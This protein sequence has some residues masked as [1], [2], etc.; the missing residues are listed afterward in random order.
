MATVKVFNDMFDEKSEEFVYDTSRPLLEQIEEHLDKDFYKSTMVECYDPQTGETFYAP[1]EDDDETE[2][3]IILVNGQSVDKDFVPEEHDVVNVIFTPLGGPNATRGAALGAWLGATAAI[4]ATAAISLIPGVNV[5]WYVVVGA[6]L[7]GGVWGGYI[8]WDKGKEKDRAG[9][10]LNQKDGKDSDQLPDV[11]GC[12]NQSLV[13]NNFP[14]VIGKHLVTPFIV[15]DPYT[16]YV[17]GRGKDAYVRILLCV[18]YGPLKLTDFKLGDYMLAYNRTHPVN[19]KSYTTMPE[20]AVEGM[21]VKYAGTTGTYVNGKYYKYHSGS[22]GVTTEYRDTATGSEVVR[23]T[24]MAGLLTGYST[25]GVPDNGD[26]VDFWSNNSVSIEII[27]QSN[28]DDELGYG[29]AAYADQV[30]NGD[31]Y[32]FGTLYPEVT[33]EQKVDANCFYIA[34]KELQD[35]VPVSYKGVSFPNKYRTN[36]VILTDSCPREFTINLDLPSGLYRTRTETS[37]NTS[38]VVYSPI[39]LWMCIQWR[40]YSTENASSKADGSDYNDWNTVYFNSNINRTFDNTSPGPGLAGNQTFDKNLHQ[41]NDFGSATLEDIYQGFRDKELQSFYNYAGENGIDE[42]RFSATVTLTKEQCKQVIADTNPSRCIEVRCLRVSPNYM[43]QLED[44]T[45]DGK[46]MWSYSDHIKVSTVVTK[47]FDYEELR[48]NDELIPTRV[49]SEKDLRKLC[50]VAISCK[51]DA[52]GFIQ[53]NLDQITCTAESFSPIWDSTEK[54]ILPEGITK[55]EKYYGYFVGNTNTRTNRSTTATEREVTKADYEQARHDGYNWYAEKCGSNFTELMKD[56]A[57]VKSNV[58]YHVRSVWWLPDAAKK[59]NDNLSS[60]SFLLSLFG[61]QNGPE[62]SGMEDLNV[63]SIADWAETIY[64]LEDGSTA[65][66]AMDYNGVHYNTGDILPVRYEANAYIYAGIK[67]EDLLQK[68]AFT[69]RAVWVVDESGKVK[70]VFDGPVPYTKGAIASENCI[71]SS[72]AYT[73]EE[74]PAGLF[75]TFHDENDGYENNSFYV[76]SDGNSMKN[77]HGAVE[78]F[79]ADFVTNNVQMHSLARYSL[80]NR[81]LNREVLTRKIGPGG[82]IYSLGDVV[83][84][85]GEDLLIGDVSGRVQEVIE[86]D[87]KIYGFITDAVYTYT[88]ETVSQYRSTQGVTVI[89]QRYAGRSN[90][91]TFRL[92]APVTKEINGKTYVLQP[93]ETNLVLFAP[94]VVLGTE[95]WG[96]DKGNDDPSPSR[97]NQV[98]Y[99]IKTGD[100]AMYG[101]A[102]KIS[103]PYRIIKIKPEANGCFTE[104]L[105]P[106]NEDLYNY[107]AALPTFQSYITPP[108]AMVD[109]TSVS[110]VPTTL[111]D[112]ND[113]N[114]SIYKVFFARVAELYANHIVTLYKYS[115]TD[116]STAGIGT[117]LVYNFSD[118]SITWGDPSLNNGW[119][120]TVP[121]DLTDVW[122]TSATAYGQSQTDTINSNEWARPIKVGQNGVNGLNTCTISLYKRLSSTPQD[123]PAAVT[124]NFANASMVCSNWNGWSTSIP[125]VDDEDFTPCWEIHATALSTQTTDTIESSEWS[126]CVKILSEGLSKQDVLDLIGERINET[127]NVLFT[128]S[129]GMFA[130]DED[131]IVSTPQTAFMDVRVIQNDEDITFSFGQIDLP[132][133]MTV[134]ATVLEQGTR[135][136]FTVAQG[137]RL[138]RNVIKVPVIFTAYADNDVLVDENGNPLVWV[139]DEDGRWYGDC[140]TVASLPVAVS[141]GFIYWKGIDTTASEELVEGGVFYEGTFY[142]YNGTKWKESKVKPIG[143]QTEATSPTTYDIYYTASIVKGGRYDG[144][145]T[146]VAS[147][148]SNPVIGDYFTWTGTDQTPY[149]GSGFT[150]LAS[151]CVYKWNGSQ[152]EKDTSGKHLGTALPDILE[153]AESELV[154][155]NSDVVEKVGKM[156]AWNVVTQNIKVTGEALINSAIIA[157]LTLGDSTHQTSGE[158]KSYN[159]SSGSAGFKIKADGTAEFN[160]VTVRGTVY[161]SSGSFSGAI[162]AT[163]LT[164]GNGVT[165]PSNKVSGLA[166]VATSGDFDDLSNVEVELNQ[167]GT[168]VIEGG[169]I[170]TGLIDTDNL[171]AQRIFVKTG[172]SIESQSYTQGSA[173]WKIKDDGT[174][175]FNNVTIRGSVVNNSFSIDETDSELMVFKHYDYDMPYGSFVY[176]FKEAFG[177]QY[178]SAGES[179]SFDITLTDS[180]F[181]LYRNQGVVADNCN[182][183]TLDFV[184]SDPSRSATSD[185]A[186]CKLRV[187]SITRS[188]WLDI[189]DIGSPSSGYFQWE[190]VTASNMTQLSVFN[191]TTGVAKIKYGVLP[192]TESLENGVLFNDNGL[193]KISGAYQPWKY[194]E[195]N[196]GTDTKYVYDMIKPCITTQYQVSCMGY[197]GKSDSSHSRNINSISAVGGNLKFYNHNDTEYLSIPSS[198]NFG[199]E[200]LGGK[201]AVMFLSV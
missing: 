67:I 178:N 182:R 149:E 165:V 185:P 85:Q 141:G 1:M 167:L 31:T 132:T 5:A 81:I 183:F 155:N 115:E 2:G 18:G 126:E 84:I 17:G 21:V 150:K 73:Y 43:N 44:N 175:E 11:R 156:I 131:G 108:P 34:D 189:I 15:G 80:A 124:Y 46:G 142:T 187:Y 198:R 22:W 74:P 96:Y 116:L 152:W 109:P 8:G 120:A 104:T 23:N 101:L 201:L 110:D 61:A 159:Y 192:L 58:P 154:E 172:G 191:E 153:V 87:E 181:Y 114:K 196:E 94:R 169:K 188:M 157:D 180:Y 158:I 127:P 3:V 100:I 49:V 41:G 160:N 69:G 93:G 78:Q 184:F 139:E 47:T 118:D 52:S 125:E 164:L 83:L 32:G 30:V 10:K 57:M 197:Y 134:S 92:S 113:S 59:Y 82:A 199:Q 102:D 90:A 79:S 39:T 170:K 97:S 98:K 147:I 117:T 129:E 20:S 76:W 16:F 146:T 162:T 38:Q 35:N 28:A 148:P 68:I 33:K 99:N 95:T 70:V 13:G 123:L 7:V 121:N 186:Y 193:L 12:S 51:A 4:F 138:E 48:D 62:G 151:G 27:Q 176:M 50:F 29:T 19:I 200:Y 111:V 140:S 135:L 163:S 45:D 63:I 26:I 133:G 190:Q 144:G 88:G 145:I 25:G 179:N 75:T 14:Y 86:D 103:A 105:I 71:S 55:V 143:I 53:S 112:Q 161:A 166:T 177:L 91:V 122:V 168:T 66:S 37:G 136:N 173:G 130:V 174:A 40:V 42:M 24:M 137:T 36:T 119:S 194:F 195:F 54:K 77:H 107:G 60:S 9:G 65:P 128:P 72:N 171:F 56:I 106:Y 6:A 89:Q 64:G